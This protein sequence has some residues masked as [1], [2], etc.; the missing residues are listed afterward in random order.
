[1]LNA[2]TKKDAIEAGRADSTVGVTAMQCLGELLTT[3]THFNFRINIMTAVVSKMSTK[4]PIDVGIIACN[5]MRTLFDNDVSGEASCEAVKLISK[6]IKGKN[7]K[8][9][10]SVL[11]TFLHLKLKDELTIEDVQ[12]GGKN[13]KKRKR[14][15]EPHI[16]KKVRKALKKDVEV[17]K[18]LKEA[19]AEYSREEKQK[20]H[21]E[22]LKYVFL[23]YFRVLKNADTSPLLP[24]V[25]EGLSQ[26][27]HLI[28]VDFFADILAVL[29]R[30]TL[31]HYNSYADGEGSSSAKSAFH[32]IIAAFQLLTGQGEAI[33]IDLKDFNTSLYTQLMRLPMNP[34]FSEPTFLSGAD[35]TRVGPESAATGIKH[36][37]DVHSRC[38]IELAMLGLDLLFCRKKQVCHH[39]C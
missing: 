9:E 25:L 10:E 3:L 14:D 34:A 26:F 7:F 2:N 6:M 33:N 30:I 35:D 11:K 38:E 20:L 16:S 23:T 5:A 8:V 32:C 15:K 4:T 22:T 12:S 37:K 21:T 17:E 36:M 13:G 31:E 29:K 18:E 28:N 39:F 1:M 24:A 19:E 27:A